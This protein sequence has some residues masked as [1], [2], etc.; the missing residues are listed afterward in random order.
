MGKQLYFF[1][2]EDDV[3]NFLTHLEKSGG[4]IIINSIAYA[5]TKMAGT[6][7]SEM[8]SGICQYLI[9]HVPDASFL[10]KSR[11]ACIEDGTAIEFSNCRR[12][13]SNSCNY[14]DKGRIYLRTTNVGVYDAHTLT[15]YKKL[16]QYFRKEYIYDKKWITYFSDSAKKQYESHEILLSQLGHPLSYSAHDSTDAF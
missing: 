16:Y 11:Y 14:L 15:L 7:V 8:T 6:I 2:T 1:H 9:A 5:P 10:K 13:A 3:V 4:K 12:W